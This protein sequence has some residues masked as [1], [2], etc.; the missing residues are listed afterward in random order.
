MKRVNYARGRFER[1]AGAPFAAIVTAEMR[2]PLAA[3]GAAVALTGAVCGVQEARLDAARRANDAYA[4]RLAAVEPSAERAR[5]DR[6]ELDR[7]RAIARTIDEVAQ[8]GARGA[9]AI[10]ALGNALPPGAWLT[11]LRADRGTIALDGRGARLTAVADAIVALDALG[12]YG[13]VRLTNARADAPRS[14]VIYDLALQAA[15]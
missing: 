3:L 13:S 11:A 6:R 14:G 2:R 1:I 10:A 12:T 9:S 15:P 5:A 7:L 8:S 4:I